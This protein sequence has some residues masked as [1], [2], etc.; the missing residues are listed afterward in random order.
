M[1]ASKK[2]YC[3]TM[4]LNIGIVFYV[5]S[6]L[7]FINGM[8]EEHKDNVLYNQND[9]ALESYIEDLSHNA[10]RLARR[11]SYSSLQ[12]I[13][14]Q[15]NAEFFARALCYLNGI[16]GK[17]SSI[18]TPQELI[19]RI[20]VLL[21]AP[22]ITRIDARIIIVAYL[23]KNNHHL[24]ALKDHQGRTALL[25]LQ[26]AFHSLYNQDQRI[27]RS[28]M[29]CKNNHY[30]GTYWALRIAYTIDNSLQ[31][32]EQIMFDIIRADSQ[33]PEKT[34]HLID[35]LLSNGMYSAEV[36]ELFDTHDITLTQTYDSNGRTA[37]MLAT[38]N[39]LN[40]IV[41]FLGAA[42]TNTNE[43]DD[44]TQNTALHYGVEAGNA[45][46]IETLLALGALHTPNASGLYPSNRALQ[47]ADIHGTV[48][49]L[50][51]LQS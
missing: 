34:I 16:H 46:A 40:H 25:I 48:K 32:I 38:F 13:R 10:I 7:T 27:N 35:Y 37:L 22:G 9:E 6:S 42:G 18:K 28:K 50:R 15:V 2:Q 29:P 43:A 19:R 47:L 3:K 39:N 1:D 23:V 44:I 14:W 12:S 41:H 31:N 45:E 20:T 8:E 51:I 49:T 5:L 17:L 24:L 26:D 36:L 4:I 33:N 11:T 21:T 30:V